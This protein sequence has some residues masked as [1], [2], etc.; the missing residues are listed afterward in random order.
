MWGHISIYKIRWLERIT[1]GCCGAICATWCRCRNI[2][3]R[4]I[5]GQQN[6]RCHRCTD[7]RNHLIELGI[8]PMDAPVWM[9]Y[10]V[11]CCTTFPS[12]YYCSA[13]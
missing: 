3:G 4:D 10:G 5:N 7:F 6:D 11:T 2:S 9:P 8:I 12:L 13:I 1:H